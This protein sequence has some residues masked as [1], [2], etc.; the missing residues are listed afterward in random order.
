MSEELPK[1]DFIV[2]V[3]AYEKS[4]K[5][6]P[7]IMCFSLDITCAEVIFGTLRNLILTLPV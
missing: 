3:N 7:K 5:I 6:L 1:E 2:T 4:I